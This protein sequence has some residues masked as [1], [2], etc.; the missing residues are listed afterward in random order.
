MPRGYHFVSK[1]KNSCGECATKT[2]LKMYGKKLKKDIYSFEGLSPN[3]IISVL[4]AR[5][6]KTVI[7]YKLYYEH[8]KPKSIV[9]YN[10]KLDHYVVVGA[11]KTDKIKIYDSDKTKAIWLS[12]KTFE[13]KWTN[14][15][16]F[17][18]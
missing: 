17:T 6:I 14:W 10:S 18:K 9:Y 2:I 12:R 3:K 1:R 4:N 11:I 13:K 15:A 7:R 5:K 8:L 16:I